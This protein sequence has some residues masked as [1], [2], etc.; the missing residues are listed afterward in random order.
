M[1]VSDDDKVSIINNHIRNI[2]LTKY[3]S[4]IMLMTQQAISSPDQRLIDMYTAQIT[5]ANLQLS[6]LAEQKNSLTPKE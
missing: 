4:E 2:E 5:D 3:T 6:I 1:S